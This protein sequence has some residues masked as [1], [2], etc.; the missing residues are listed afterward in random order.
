MKKGKARQAAE[1]LDEIENLK[2]IDDLL[3]NGEYGAT[4]HFEIK[5]HYGKCK[6]YEKI[7]INK[8]YNPR[9]IDVVK[10]IISELELE[11]DKL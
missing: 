8:K 9:L 6:E 11:L 5:Q 10:E 1:I 3:T 4:V 2:K 7:E